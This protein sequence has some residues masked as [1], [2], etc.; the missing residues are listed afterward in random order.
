VLVGSLFS[1]VAFS[2]AVVVLVYSTIE[3]TKGRRHT[4]LKRRLLSAGASS[5]LSAHAGAVVTSAASHVDGVVMGSK[6]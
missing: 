1:V 2:H 3:Y 5:F 4:A 6:S